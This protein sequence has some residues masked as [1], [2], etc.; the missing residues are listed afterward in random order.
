MAQCLLGFGRELRVRSALISDPARSW[1]AAGPER[2]L[3]AR[4]LTEMVPK[5]PA[6]RKGALKAGLCPVAAALATNNRW[7]GHLSKQERSEVGNIPPAPCV[8]L[9]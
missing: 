1:P 6:Q 2:T 8:S 7:T 4:A 3:R 5:F 9:A